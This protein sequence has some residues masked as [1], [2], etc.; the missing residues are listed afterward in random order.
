MK[1][2]LKELAG[3]LLQFQRA[4]TST[5]D[6]CQANQEDGYDARRATDV[7]HANGRLLAVSVMQEKLS[8]LSGPVID[9]ETFLASFAAE[10][11]DVSK[12]FAAVAHEDFH[13]LWGQHEAYCDVVSTV[14]VWQYLPAPCA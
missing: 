12:K 1:I 11:A 4:A 8:M 13:V 14:Q 10:S 3:M 5:R 2:T 6:K 7:A 9:A